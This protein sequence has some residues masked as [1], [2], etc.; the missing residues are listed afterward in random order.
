M[1]DLNILKISVLAI[2]L[3]V[4]FSSCTRDRNK[5]GYV[6]F[7]D[8]AESEAYEYYSENPNF[9]NGITAQAPVAGTIPREMMPYAY[10]RTFAGQQL[11]GK[12]LTNPVELTKENLKQGK[13]QYDLFCAMCHGNLGESDGHLYT[14]KKFTAMPTKLISKAIQA[15]PDGEIYHVITLGTLSQLMG[16][17]GSQIKPADRWKITH[18]IKNKFSTTPK[19]RVAATDDAATAGK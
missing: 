13:A 7:P 14:D 5:P 11:A 12:E 19:P 4:L 17:H 8:M 10:P 9:A 2:L 1:K 3:A 15:K 6:Y 18:Y 16:A